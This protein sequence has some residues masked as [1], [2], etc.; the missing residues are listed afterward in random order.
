[1]SFSVDRIEGD[2]AVLED[3]NGVLQTVPLAQLPPDAREGAVL[4]LENGVW[5]LDADEAAR[6]RAEALRLQALL[7]KKKR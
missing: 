1:M 2:L 6:R 5:T 3:E 4:R 7:R